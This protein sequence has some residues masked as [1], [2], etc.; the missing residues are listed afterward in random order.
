MR[1]RSNAV[2]RAPWAW[3]VVL[4]VSIGVRIMRNA[5]ALRDELLSIHDSLSNSSTY[6]RDAKIVWIG[7]GS[8][9]KY[10]FDWSKAKIPALAPVSPNLP[11]GPMLS[12]NRLRYP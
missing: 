4:R 3:S 10:V 9:A 2:P 11:T 12:T 1:R 6:Q 8:L 5:A 7:K